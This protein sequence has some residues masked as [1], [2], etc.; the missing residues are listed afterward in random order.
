MDAIKSPKVHIATGSLSPSDG[1]LI[2]MSSLEF[3]LRAQG[4]RSLHIA[5]LPSVGNGQCLPL[6]IVLVF[7][8]AVRSPVTT[9]SGRSKAPGLLL[10]RVV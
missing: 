8:F 5:V 6:I 1:N 4:V 9:P 2:K 10:P 3:L 7:V